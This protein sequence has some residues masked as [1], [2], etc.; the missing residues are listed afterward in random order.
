LLAC[1]NWKGFVNNWRAPVV[2]DVFHIVTVTDGKIH[3]AAVTAQSRFR[4]LKYRNGK[5]KFAQH[6]VENKQSIVPMEDIL[7]VL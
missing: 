5:S 3:V 6:V 2:G 1:V 4:D 7:E